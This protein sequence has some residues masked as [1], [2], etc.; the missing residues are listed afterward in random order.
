MNMM[1]DMMNVNE[2]DEQC[3]FWVLRRGELRGFSSSA[4]GRGGTQRFPL[5]KFRP[6][7][8]STA[9]VYLL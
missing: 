2:E 8:T 5:A 7:R 4:S 1:K 3:V 9:N 6:R